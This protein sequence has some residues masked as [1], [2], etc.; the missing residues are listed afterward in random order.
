MSASRSLFER[1]DVIFVASVSCIYG[2]G[3]PEAYYGILV[4]LEKG[5]QTSREALLPRFVDIQYE[6][7]EDLRRG[8]FCVPGDIL[9]I[10]PT[11]QDNP[12]LIEMWGDHIDNLH[13]PH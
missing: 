6:R 9:E 13:Q 4:M 7:S 2:I 3:S 11:Y 12:Y 1:Q 5:F 8:T 10:Y